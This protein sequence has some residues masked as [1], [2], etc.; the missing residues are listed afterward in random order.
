MQL[1]IVSTLYQSSATIEEFII[2]ITRCVQKVT[3]DYELIIVND[4]SPDDSLQ[5]TLAAQKLDSHIKIIDLSRNFGHHEAGMTGID[6]SQGDFVFLIDSDLEE[7]PEIFLEFWQELQHR[8]DLDVIYGIQQQRKGNWFEQLSGTI[9]YI[10]FNKL[11][12]IKISPNSLTIRLMKR[13]YVNAILQYQERNL[14]AAGIMAHAGFNQQEKIVS[15]K[16]RQTSSYTFAKRLHLLIVCITSFSSKLLHYVF[17]TG[18]GILF[19]SLLA[20]AYFC[21]DYFF[22]D[23]NISTV[24]AIILATGT[25]TGSLITCTGLLGFYINSISTEVKKRPRTIIKT[26]YSNSNN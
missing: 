10:I 7:A 6:H 19:V 1:S 13:H 9:F 11:S 14:F 8:Q 5:K 3:Q 2:R 15:K 23:V 22:Y 16:S 21:F 12:E 17:L 18:G 4:G 20:T 24:K 25:I 26:I